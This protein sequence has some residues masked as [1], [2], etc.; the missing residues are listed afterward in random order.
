[1]ARKLERKGKAKLGVLSHYLSFRG[2]LT[3]SLALVVGDAILPPVVMYGSPVWGRVEAQGSECVRR[4]S[5]MLKE[6]QGRLDKIQIELLRLVFGGHDRGH[7]KAI[8]RAEAGWCSM[9]LRIAESIVTYYGRV[10][11][12]ESTRPVRIFL[13]HAVELE[14]SRQNK[15]TQMGIKFVRA[16]KMVFGAG[17]EVNFGGE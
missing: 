4:A 13:S 17:G 2:A 10:H 9:D 7:M 6:E 15:T 8:L 11:R 14:I 16:A 1:M 3:P 5:G 12:M